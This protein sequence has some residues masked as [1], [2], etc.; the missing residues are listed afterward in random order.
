MTDLQSIINLLPADWRAPL[1]TLVAC[2]GTARLLMKPIGSWLKSLITRAAEKAS[3]SLD[4]DDETI[5]EDILTTRG[6]RAIAFLLD[7]F[8]SVKLPA[9]EDL[10][11][12]KS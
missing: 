3:L 12:P 7:L 10:F 8:A 6:Y 4:P 5:I 2:I 1:L 9:K 11:K